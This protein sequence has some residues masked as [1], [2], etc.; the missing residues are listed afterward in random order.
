MCTYYMTEL[1]LFA[2][3]KYSRQETFNCQATHQVA[4][5]PAAPRVVG[6][7]QSSDRSSVCRLFTKF[8]R[9][10]ATEIAILLYRG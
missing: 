4:S 6:T 8:I 9:A 1:H 3:F 2:T 10:C 7:N 5:Q